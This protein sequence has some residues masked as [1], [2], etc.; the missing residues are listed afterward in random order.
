MNSIST[1]RF[2]KAAIAVVVILSL[3]L[4]LA[5]QTGKGSLA[6]PSY[7]LIGVVVLLCVKLFVK[8]IRLEALVLGVLLFGYIVGQSGFG[9]FSFSPTKGI[10]L[11]EIGLTIC[12]TA[13]LTRLA[14]TRERIIPKQLLALGILAF[15]VIGTLRFIY[16]FRN[17]VNG[18]D[19]V[20]DFATI[21]YAAFFFIAFNACRHSGSRLFLQRTITV[22]LV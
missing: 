7:F 21:Y 17:S 4:Y 1:G 3:G 5:A 22:A 2:W 15:I 19:V 9:H 18:T 6:V 13:V 14:F 20:R 12:S 8:Y 11:G 10:Y 16:D